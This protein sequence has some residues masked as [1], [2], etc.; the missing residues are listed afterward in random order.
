M[1]HP[2]TNPD[3][4]VG[5]RSWSDR[6]SDKLF[7]YDFFISYAWD[8]GRFYA[9]ELATR[10]RAHGFDCF[11][12]S[13]DY[14]RGDDLVQIGAWA[15]LRTHRLI[16]IG[17]PAALQSVHVAREI[18][19]YARR[20]QKIIPINFG[21]CL[22][23]LT[24]THAV[25]KHISPNLL[26]KD[27]ALNPA[28]DGPTEETV[29]EI[30]AAFEGERQTQK[31]LRWIRR[32]AGVLGA[33]FFA[34]VIFGLYAI[35]QKNRANRQLSQVDWEL[36]Q[37]ARGPNYAPVRHSDL[38]ATHLLYS[39]AIAASR[40]GDQ[41]AARSAA[42]A[43]EA[44]GSRLLFRIGHRSRIK[45][46][47]Y[48]PDGRWIA[49][50]SDDGEVKISDAST[51]NFQSSIKLAGPSKFIGGADDVSFSAD[52]TKLL[53]LADNEAQV[54]IVPSGQ[55]VGTRIQTKGA[56]SWGSF[57]PGTECVL[58]V[59][60]G[61]GAMLC[62]PGATPISF[63]HPS[64]AWGALADPGLRQVMTWGQDRWLVYWDA[65][66]GKEAGRVD[67]GEVVKDIKASPDWS[68]FI[69]ETK[70][71]KMTLRSFFGAK[72]LRSLQPVA[73]DRFYAMFSDDGSRIFTSSDSG[74]T[75][76]YDRDGNPIDLSLAVGS[77]M[78]PIRYLQQTQQLMGSTPVGSFQLWTIGAGA[79]KPAR[80]IVAGALFGDAQLD[81]KNRIVTADYDGLVRIWNSQGN[82]DE[83][84]IFGEKCF[85]VPTLSPSRDRIL[86]ASDRAARVY[87]IDS[88]PFLAEEIRAP[89]QTP[90]AGSAEGF[91]A[92]LGDKDS[93]IV[94]PSPRSKARKG[95]FSLKGHADD[96]V[97]HPRMPMA[98]VWGRYDTA[99]RV[100]LDQ[101]P[102][103]VTPLAT[104]SVT[105]V[106]FSRDGSRIAL[107]GEFWLEIWQ[108]SPM[109]LERRI[110]KLV[111]PVEHVSFSPN[112]DALLF[113]AQNKSRVLQ[114]GLLSRMKTQY[115]SQVGMMHCTNGTWRDPDLWSVDD[116]MRGC[117]AG[118]A[119]RGY[120]WSGDKAYSARRGIRELQVI[121]DDKSGRL[122]AS[123][124]D[125]GQKALWYSPKTGPTLFDLTSETVI[126]R[127]PL[128]LEMYEAK[129]LD[130]LHRILV[131]NTSG[132]AHILPFSESEPEAPP[133]LM[134]HGPT[135]VVC[136]GH[137]ILACF[138]TK[139]PT[140]WDLDNS[141]ILTEFWHPEIFGT[142]LSDETSR[143]LLT[144][145]QDGVIRIWRLPD[146]A[147]LDDPDRLAE[148]F[149]RRSG[150][151][152]GPNL[153]PEPFP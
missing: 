60:S 74:G 126:R 7:G 87:R 123:L 68:R 125:D 41:E 21:K 113:W 118:S 55:P 19:T 90:V 2:V 114:R 75:C 24:E 136:V 57:V 88:S 42:L 26:R 100:D 30:I 18:Q 97:L 47:K 99:R 44:H 121:L 10:L 149:R 33:L 119:E 147:T 12:D 146:V 151:R 134:G 46:A 144:E 108:T 28:T 14:K 76:V 51:G 145:S 53:A 124:S 66:T 86:I 152:L 38:Q 63:E 142:I 36:G 34:S 85:P 122:D 110:D 59:E 56:I 130:Q 8:D 54:S 115:A 37:A 4:S 111:G 13:D 93:I 11:L 103:V 131:W 112:G 1:S 109:R 96:L 84:P 105:A 138:S 23:D 40:A 31:R 70:S 132:V 104:K 29:K 95:I 22:P 65:S 94:A 150:S 20:K 80:E 89:W 78:L 3:L 25:G 82:E 6:I 27:E 61:K 101:S 62:K 98:I 32:F 106:K 128:P 64:P 120:V 102:P 49:T 143:E 83:D 15:L 77:Y 139:T 48:S 50:G 91:F 72:T 17:T 153:E 117:V 5:R 133:L 137:L 52:G 92:A 116:M 58:L 9:K 148:E 39:A 127:W 107:Y 140:L 135:K 35:Q 79:T 69:L 67:C 73:P 16:L 81:A 71:G 43:A 45:A 141:R 129:L